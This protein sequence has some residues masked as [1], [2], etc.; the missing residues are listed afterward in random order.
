VDF[1]LNTERGTAS[2]DASAGV[3]ETNYAIR[4][5]GTLVP[6]AGGVYTVYVDSDNVARVWVNEVL[7][8]NKTAAGRATVDGH[9]ALKAGRGYPI[10]VEYVHASG[11]SNMHL[12]WA[13]AGMPRQPVTVVPD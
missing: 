13:S 6:P 1:D 3:S 10:R 7:V 4:W 5:R 2:P 12:S 8:L 11:P 9:I